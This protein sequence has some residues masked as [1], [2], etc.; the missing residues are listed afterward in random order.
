VVHARALRPLAEVAIENATEGC[1]RETYG[2]MVAQRQ[3]RKAADPRVRSVLQQIAIDE[4]RHAALSWEVDT[5]A[6]RKLGRF[7]R[8]RLRAARGQAIER[9]RRELAADPHPALQRD[10]GLA[11]AEEASETAGRLFKALT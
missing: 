3:A 10:A 7:D 4:A 8:S 11:S 6:Q 2:A 1:V 9:L 5:W